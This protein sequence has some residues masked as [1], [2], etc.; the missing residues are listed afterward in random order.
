MPQVRRVFV[1]LPPDFS[2]G[3]NPEVSLAPAD[4][5]HLSRVLRLKPGSLVAVTARSSA[6]EYQAIIVSG[7]A[8]EMR[9][10]L[11]TPCARQNIRGRV[12]SLVFALSKGSK[13][14]LVCEKACELGVQQIVFWQAC[15]SVVEL[16]ALKQ[17]SQR[18]ARWARIAES[19]AKQSGKNYVP[20]VHLA[21]SL[22][23]VMSVIEKGAHSLDRFFCC[24]LSAASVAMNKVEA[25]SG[26]VHLAV[27][28]EGD[29]TAQEEK[30]FESRNFQL[31]SLGPFVLRS[32]TA[33]IAAVAMAQGL[34]GS[35]ASQ[36]V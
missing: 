34:W 35:L 19:A 8:K 7:G 25:P 31:V 21:S 32:E 4:A 5:H 27:G 16:S 13:N 28:P 10:K 9:V 23:E 20:Q 24:S 36:D 12:K 1:D 26:Y 22:D 6:E 3:N 29:L 30:A 11:L 2:L 15:R 33:A 14:D 17:R 18:L